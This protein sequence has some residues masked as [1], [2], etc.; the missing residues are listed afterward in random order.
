VTVRDDYITYCKCGEGIK[1]LS[2]HTAEGRVN[3]CI[4]LEGQ[5]VTKLET[6]SAVL[7]FLNLRHALNGELTEEHALC[8]LCSSVRLYVEECNKFLNKIVN[9]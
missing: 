9:T 2:P 5:G 3:V 8:P 1:P 4:T 6:C 7:S